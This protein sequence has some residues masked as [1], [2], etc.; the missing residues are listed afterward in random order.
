MLSICI[1]VDIPKAG[2]DQFYKFSLLDLVS[3][4]MHDYV[5]I[6]KVNFT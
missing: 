1:E 3:A 2:N 5:A 4:N 6:F